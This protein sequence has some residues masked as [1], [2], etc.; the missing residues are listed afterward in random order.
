MTRRMQSL[1]LSSLLF[2]ASQP[3]RTEAGPRVRLALVSLSQITSPDL[4]PEFVLYGDGEA[5][6]RRRE[7]GRYYACGLSTKRADRFVASL[8]LGQLSE[9]DPESSILDDRFWKLVVATTSGDRVVKGNE[10]AAGFAGLRDVIRLIGKFDCSKNRLWYPVAAAIA[11]WPVTDADPRQVVD[12][13][14][15]WPRP[16]A[17]TP[18]PAHLAGARLVSRADG[19]R[20]Y[21]LEAEVRRF[22]EPKQRFV[23]LGG[24][25]YVVRIHPVF[26]L[27][28]VWL[29]E[30]EPAAP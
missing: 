9:P 18:V 25:A 6:I 10:G 1:V 21:D 24:Q 20:F 15:D 5:V 29:E 22:N 2:A 16:S 30:R 23:Q 13:P 12:C 14:S 3:S 7:D 28:R 11:F 26:P 17:L 27:E 19:R 8:H 4:R